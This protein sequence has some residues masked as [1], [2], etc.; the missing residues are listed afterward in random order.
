MNSLLACTPAH[1]REEP[2]QIVGPLFRYVVGL[3]ALV[4]IVHKLI[5]DPTEKSPFEVVYTSLPI[6]TFDLVHLSCVIDDSIEAEAMA[7]CISK[8]YQEVNNHLDLANGSY[9]MAT[10]SH[11]HFKEYQVDNL[12]M[13]YLCKS[14]LPADHHSKMTNAH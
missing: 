7:A 4:P 9:K 13:V 2:I 6:V 3:Y 10:N 11:K 14:R 8:L 12:V 5:Y 1:E